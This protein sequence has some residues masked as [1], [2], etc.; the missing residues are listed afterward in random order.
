MKI[1]IYGMTLRGT[2]MS[3]YATLLYRNYTVDTHCFS[4]AFLQEYAAWIALRLLLLLSIDEALLCSYSASIGMSRLVFQDASRVGFYRVLE[5]G[6]IW[7]S[8]RSNRCRSDDKQCCQG[9]HNESRGHSTVKYPP[10]KDV[11]T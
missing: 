9:G 2:D 8:V 10:T 6:V 7:T 3:I 1:T 5:G 11:S 4:R